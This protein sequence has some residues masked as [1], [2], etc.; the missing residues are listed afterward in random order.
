VL[1]RAGVTFEVLEYE[2]D[3]RAQAYG[4]EAA[5]RLG[6]APDA[7]FKTLVTR[8]DGRRVTALVPVHR[9]LD[10]KTLAAAVGA[11]RAEMAEAAEAERATGYVVGGISPL[12]Q[13]R[14]LLTVMDHRAMDLGRVFVSAG[15][16]G[17][18]IAL[19]PSDLQALCG[20]RLAALA[21]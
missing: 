11:R 15:R 20:A 6:V 21:R 9:R 16:R 1:E 18:E 3:P 4:A 17:L 13:R 12:G 10:L 5:E 8:A 14:R 2:H 7:V 19:R